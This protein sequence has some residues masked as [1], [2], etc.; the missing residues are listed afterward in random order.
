MS[1]GHGF[2]AHPKRAKRPEPL[3]AKA[4]GVSVVKKGPEEDEA[5]LRKVR[6]HGCLVCGRPAEAH[7]P[8][9][10]FAR[11]GGRR[12]SDYLAVPL[13]PEHHKV[14]YPGSL[15]Y[16]GSARWWVLMD[17]DVVGWIARFSEEGRAALERYPPIALL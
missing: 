3:V 16:F 15:H 9:E 7:H 12:K 14:E 8:R 4:L 1:R 13:C 2:R 10:L 5:H 17:I 6:A 11:T